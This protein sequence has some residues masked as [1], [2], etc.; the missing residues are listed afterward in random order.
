MREE[1]VRRDYAESTI[2]QLSAHHRGFS[3]VR[4]EAARSSGTGR[5]PALPGLPAGRAQARYRNGIE[6]C[7]RPPVFLREDAEAPFGERGFALPARGEAQTAP[8]DHPEPGR[9]R[10]A[11]RLI[12]K[13]FP[14]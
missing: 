6:L 2:P 14:F 12:Q 4:S 10:P 13:S 9:S 11:D 3:A 7:C 5:H 8:A 1:L